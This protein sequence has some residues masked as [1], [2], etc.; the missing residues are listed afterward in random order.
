MCDVSSYFNLC[1]SMY[2]TYG[3]AFLREIADP[4][5][6]R[7]VVSFYFELLGYIL[8]PLVNTVLKLNIMV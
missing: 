3:S 5:S 1:A 8:C 4:G 2:Q 7:N 6:L